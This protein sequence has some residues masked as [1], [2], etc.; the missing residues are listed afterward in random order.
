MPMNDH[1]DRPAAVPATRPGADR[2]PVSP[3]DAG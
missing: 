3:R 1:A 2:C